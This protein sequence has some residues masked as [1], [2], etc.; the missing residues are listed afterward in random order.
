MSFLFESLEPR[1][2]LTTLPAGFTQVALAS[3]LGTPTAMDVLPDGRVLIST[4]G[5]DL[6]V[7]KNGAL[8]STP[9]LQLDVDSRGSRGLLGVAHDPDFTSNHFIYLYHTIPSGNAQFPFNEVTRYTMAGDTVVAGSA[10]DILQ[11]GNLGSNTGDN[12]GDLRFGLDGF[13]YITTGDAGV[14]STAQSL[15]NLLGKVLRIDV[16]QVTQLTPVND[17][18][19]IVPSSN[20]F[21]VQALGL[22]E[23]IYALGLR[24]PSSLAVSPATGAIMVTD[25]GAQTSEVESLTPKANYGAAI[26]EGFGNPANPPSVPGPGTY[27]DP[28]LAYASSEGISSGTFYVPPAGAAHPFGNAFLGKYFYADA[29]GDFIRMFDPTDPGSFTNPDTST[30]FATNTVHSPVAVAIGLDGSLLYLAQ[31][32]G[33]QLL[34]IL[35]PDPNA[36]V[37]TLQPTNQKATIGHAATFTA[38]ATAP[39]PFTYQ[40]Q[41]NN[42]P[43][44]AFADI[45]GATSASFTLPAVQ[46]TDK[47]ANFRV[48]ASN[49]FGSITSNV[50]ALSV[51]KNKAPSPK[52]TIT[53][54]LR[55]GKFTAGTPINFSLSATDPE[56]G[57]E[58]ASQFSYHVEYLTQ[59]N[60]VHGGV[61]QFVIPP[62]TGQASDTFTPTTPAAKDVL[63]RIVFTVT[64]SD[65]LAK[66]IHKDIKPAKTQPT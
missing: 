49:T 46:S 48:I 33:G 39:V 4:Q 37:I 54:G 60:T 45:A 26:L 2:Q 31:G 42:G 7:V 34:H 23:A 58:P 52:I 30:P 63:Y 65:G 13:L 56:D 43:H 3:N 16:S 61:S 5:G 32:N 51:A 36:P 47:A 27:Q 11:M 14:P 24:D 29:S 18:A 10:V 15:N 66:T 9:A 64:D 22:N 53:S 20:P 12:G 62:T 25:V 50:V 19:I 38:A 41:R 44:G 40:W 28:Q 1:L 55:D 57:P 8:L 6:R 59:L 35:A 17:S 21:F